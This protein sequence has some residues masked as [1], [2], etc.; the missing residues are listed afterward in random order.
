LKRQISILL[1]KVPDLISVAL[2]FVFFYSYLESGVLLDPGMGWHLVIGSYT[3]FNGVIPQSDPFLFAPEHE[4][5]VHDQWLGSLILHVLVQ[6]GGMGFI[7][8]VFGVIIW[9]CFYLHRSYLIQAFDSNQ[10]ASYWFSSIWML[11]CLLASSTAWIVRPVAI[12]YGF[13]S[14]LLFFFIKEREKGFSVRSLFIFSILFM[15]WSNIHGAW[16]IGLVWI[17]IALFFYGCSRREAG[18]YIL[19]PIISSLSTL[20][21]PYGY[22]LH[23]SIFALLSSEYFMSL[24]E[25]WLPPGLSDQGYLHFF[26][27]AFLILFIPLLLRKVKDIPVYMATLVLLT[28]SFKSGRNIPFFAISSMVAGAGVLIVFFEKFGFGQKPLGTNREK[29]HSLF[30]RFGFLGLE[31]LSIL[32]VIMILGVNFLITRSPL[33]L[34]I[35]LESSL[36]SVLKSNSECTKRLF[37]HPDWGGALIYHLWPESKIFI[38][39]RNQVTSE[40]KYKRFFQ[41]LDSIDTFNALISSYRVT[42]ILV[43]ERSGIA[44]DLITHEDWVMIMES[45][46][47]SY[48]EIQFYCR[49]EIL[50]HVDI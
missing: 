28:F 49:K 38:D 12:S 30:F 14:M 43:Q 7:V 24:N 22:T 15:L 37:S 27:L 19:I 50:K 10:Y 11:F 13:F 26:I 42:G 41:A 45:Y 3:F 6:T 36:V 18:I 39:D 47:E 9:C 48:G 44:K 34:P 2:C 46:S 4:Y 31:R 40:E 16:L 20:I 35:R 23:R 21:N 25:E 17:S 5:W 29:V 1:Y 8:L 32:L 33:S